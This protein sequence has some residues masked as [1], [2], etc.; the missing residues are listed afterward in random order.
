MA[1]TSAGAK[2]G[3]ATR[4]GSGSGLAANRYAAAMRA[5]NNRGRR[6]VPSASTRPLKGGGTT[7]PW[8]SMDAAKKAWDNR[9]RVQPK[10]QLN[11]LDRWAPK[12]SSSS[13]KKTFAAR[14]THAESLRSDWKR[15]K[16]GYGGRS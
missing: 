5:W 3:W 14:V 15:G 8:N 16:W 9:G 1:G 2:K 13:R 12:Q 4:K 7:Q 11:L 6:R 10:Q